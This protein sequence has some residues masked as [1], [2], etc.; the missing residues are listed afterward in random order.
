MFLISLDQDKSAAVI[1][2]EIIFSKKKNGISDS[3]ILT[4]IFEK[5]NMKSILKK[6]L[7][8]LQC[9]KY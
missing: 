1:P 4:Q 6:S 7:E 2:G 3:L 8:K 9:N 5:K